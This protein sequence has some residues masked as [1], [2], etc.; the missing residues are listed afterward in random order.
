MASFNIDRFKSNLD[1][2]GTI[3]SN[4]FFVRIGSYKLRDGRSTLTSRQDSELI[5][6]RADS[7]QWPGV[8]LDTMNTN[9]YGIGPSQKFPINASFNDITISF[10]DTKDLVIWHLI[11]EWMSFGIFDFQGVNA[12]RYVP[13]YT[14]EYMKDYSTS[15]EINIF[16]N[17]GADITND[18]TFIKNAYKEANPVCKVMLNEAYPIALNY[19]SLNWDNNNSLFKVTTTFTFKNWYT[20]SPLATQ[21]VT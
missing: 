17:K 3:Q 1:T 15:I 18:E 2:F 5:S 14:L 8:N 6:F 21:F 4:K 20:D 10:I 13:K 7:V 9:R 16:N 11:S 19:N 12:G